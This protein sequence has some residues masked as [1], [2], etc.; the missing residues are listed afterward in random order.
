V[1]DVSLG[2]AQFCASATPYLPTPFQ[3]NHER[4]LMSVMQLD[5][6]SEDLFSQAANTSS[7]VGAKEEDLMISVLI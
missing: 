6:E 3:N 5:L 2:V 1:A 7:L 4:D